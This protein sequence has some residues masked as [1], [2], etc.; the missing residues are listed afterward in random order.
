MNETNSERWSGKKIAL[1]AIAVIFGAWL[2]G[3][4]GCALSSR[5]TPESGEIT[6]IRNG[7]SFGILTDWFD[8]HKIRE[9]IPNGSGG[10]FTGLGS[11]AHPYPASEQQRFFRLQTCE[12]EHNH[13]V[14]CEG[15]DDVAI[16]VPTADGV[17][18]G[19]EGTTY[20]NTSFT[21]AP[22]GIDLVKH[23]D[24]QFGTRTFGE[25]D[26]HAW[27]GTLGWKAFL[28]SI[29]EPVIQNNLRETIASVTC[30]ELVSSC[31]LVQNSGGTG[32]TT[33]LAAGKA[34][35]NNVNAVQEK[36]NKG[37]QSDLNA[38]L[39]RDYFGNVRFKLTHV[40]LPPKV[41]YAVEE[42]Q[43]SFAQ[44][45]QAQAKVRSAKLEA[46]ANESKEHGYEHCPACAQIDELKAIPHSLQ[47]FAP[48]AGFAVTTR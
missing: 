31:A 26:L 40:D 15:A 16:K 32:Q 30:Q 47:T 24:T 28:A 37:L 18:V 42:A 5:T 45:T 44:I 33:S 43:A 2:L 20:L 23:F 35:L 48:G 27:E 19:I 46:E 38:T 34:N 13:E 21:N 36:V 4:G 25:H 17:E 41:A 11:T 14:P 1:V 29:V 8:N 10:K 6:V 7:A 9:V 22:E 39:Q 12:S 3:L